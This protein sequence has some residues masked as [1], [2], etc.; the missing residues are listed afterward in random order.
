MLGADRGM[1]DMVRH[2]YVIPFVSEPPVSSDTKNNASC[3][4]Q[5]EFAFAEML[6]LKALGCV[7][8]VEGPSR[9]E[10]PL[11]VV[12][13]NKMRLVVDASRHLNPYVELENTKLDSLDDLTCLVEKGEL[14]SVDDFDS[15]YWHES[16]FEYCG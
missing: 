7:R 11:S 5:A 8:E 10:L 3:E 13:S 1:V 14:C 12:F 16:M 9:V 6:R 15:G 2:G 4:R